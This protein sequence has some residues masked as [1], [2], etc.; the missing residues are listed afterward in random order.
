MAYANICYQHK[1]ENI[2]TV[3]THHA[4]SLFVFMYLNIHIQNVVIL[5]IS[6]YTDILP[7]EDVFDGSTTG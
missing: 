3:P 4:H 5:N 7:I 6:E 1:E 2:S